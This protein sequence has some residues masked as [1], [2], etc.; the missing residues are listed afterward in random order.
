MAVTGALSGS[1]SAGR[2]GLR[3]KSPRKL[4]PA[5]T[6][7]LPPSIMFCL[8]SIW[9]RLEI[10]FP[11]SCRNISSG[12]AD[13]TAVVHGEKPVLV[14]ESLNVNT[15][16]L[17]IF[18]LRG[19]PRAR[20]RARHDGRESETTSSCF[21]GAQKSSCSNVMTVFVSSSSLDCWTFNMKSHKPNPKTSLYRLTT[22]T[23]EPS[24]PLHPL[25]LAQK[26][27]HYCSR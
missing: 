14:H 21:P 10:L 4:T 6:T 8:P 24:C 13:V 27:M 22:F 7:D 20:S 19:A 23:G 3:C 12:N 9:A 17:D 26:S 18:T 5:I 11:V 16:S 1:P 25:M 15:H 2:S